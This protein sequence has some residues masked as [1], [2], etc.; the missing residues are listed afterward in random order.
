[1]GQKKG[2]VRN[3]FGKK[4]KNDPVDETKQRSV[5]NSSCVGRPKGSGRRKSKL[6]SQSRKLSKKINK[7]RKERAQAAE[8]QRRCKAVAD[9]LD[10]RK[11]LKAKY[12][13]RG[14]QQVLYM[15]V[16][17]S[18]LLAVMIECTKEAKS[19]LLMD[20]CG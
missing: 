2:V 4:G 11:Q 8:Q 17:V 14:Q 7:E 15:A 16:V 1:M 12:F 13:S 19:F 20:A 5:S 9:Y 10:Q 18:A 3:P 6:F